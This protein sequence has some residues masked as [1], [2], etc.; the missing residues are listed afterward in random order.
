MNR[1]LC[2]DTLTKGDW[3]NKEVEKPFRAFY[4][5]VLFNL[6]KT[7]QMKFYISIQE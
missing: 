6:C 2:Q 7:Q 3:P 1:N 4:P 5:Y